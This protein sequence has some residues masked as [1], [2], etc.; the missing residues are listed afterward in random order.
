MSSTKPWINLVDGAFY[1]GDPFPAY[2]WM[3]ANEPVY[4]DPESGIWG[5]TKHRDIKDLSK[6]P[7]NFSNAGG[8]RPDQGALPMMIDM[9]APDHVERRRLVSA[10]FTPVRVRAM[11]DE[12]RATCDRI[13]DA[14]IERGSC[15]LVADI[16]APLPLIV[17]GNMLGVAE[18]DRGDLLRWSDDMMKGQGS[19]DPALLEAMITAFSEYTI[20]MHGVIDDRRR[21]GK[22]DDLV[23][24]TLT[25][26]L[27]KE[28]DVTLTT[29]GKQALD[30]LV[31][32]ERFDVILC[33]LMMPVMTGM[34]LYAELTARV[35]DAVSRIVFVTGGAF[36]SSAEAFLGRVKNERLEKPFD[37]K[38][39]RDLVRKYVA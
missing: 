23:G 28:H 21:T 38:S 22:D 27:R 14:V 17:I 10:G 13:I 20:Y 6:D 37:R 36:T 26:A 32:G 2:A 34:A 31:S 29:N 18:E 9:D 25:R 5:V 24:I 11:E 19:S 1:G 3:R 7:L 16:A 8:I 12:I 4:L 39:L 15:D 35:P 33:D 30:L